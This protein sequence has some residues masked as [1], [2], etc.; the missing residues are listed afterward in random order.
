MFNCHELYEQLK[1][2]IKEENGK[3]LPI[4]RVLV[5]HFGRIL[6]TK[7]DCFVG[8]LTEQPNWTLLEE[9]NKNLFLK[10]KERKKYP[11]SE[12]VSVVFFVM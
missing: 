9:L 6:S 8:E 5:D 1:A 12:E 4:F 7:K 11:G 2:V 3:K 10:V